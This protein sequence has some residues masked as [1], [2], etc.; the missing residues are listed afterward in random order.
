M[1]NKILSPIGVAFSGLALMLGAS[2]AHAATITY[3]TT[4]T[5]SDGP[6]AASAA[7]TTSAG[8]LQL[9]LSNTLSSSV[10]RSAG[11]ALSDITFTL[12]NAPG[13]LSSTTATAQLGNVSSSG[14]VTNVTGSPTRWFGANGQGLFTVSGNTIT[15]ESIGGGQPTQMIAPS[16][17]TGAAYTNVN[18]GFGNFDPYVIGPATFNLALSG[19]SANTTITGVTFSFGTSPDTFV[20]GT[21]GST[22]PVPEPSSLILLGTGLA[23][24]TGLLRCRFLNA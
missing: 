20:A 4:G 21:T 7:F 22:P 2:S 14:T 15:L 3:T 18:N 1:A 5:G 8:S 17:G 9:V 19:I 23:G 6:L 13:T 10:I 12:S 16:L 11:Q 24:A